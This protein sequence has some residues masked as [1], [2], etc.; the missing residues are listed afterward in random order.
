MALHPE[1]QNFL[2]KVAELNLPAVQTLTPAQARTQMEQMAAARNTDPTPVAKIEALSASG[3]HGEIPVRLYRAKE[4]SEPQPLL[5]YFHGGGHVIGSPDTHDAVAR[6]LCVGAGCAVASVDYRM[7][8]EHKFPAAYDDCVA[9]TQWLAG[10]ANALGLDANRMAVGGDSAGGNLAAVVALAARDAGGPPLCFQL[11]IYPVTDYRCASGSYDTYAKG[12]GVLEADTML[13]FQ[14]HYLSRV[15]DQT[16]WRASPLL[17]QNKANLPPAL[18]MTAQCDVLHDEGVAYADTL[19][20][21][22]NEVTH[23]ECAGMI[24]GFFGLAPMIS[25]AVQAQTTAAEALREA[26]GQ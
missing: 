11:L 6:S 18:V 13:W 12:Y 1:I 23:V 15:E 25:S 19:K 17:A 2:E 26:F 21:A 20:A 10:N 7:G 4:A 24:H 14:G 22:G 16:D 9:A 8:P 5:V 3:P